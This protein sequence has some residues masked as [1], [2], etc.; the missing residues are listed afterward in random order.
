MKRRMGPCLSVTFQG[1]CKA[2]CCENKFAVVF[3]EPFV[4]LTLLCVGW[5]GEGNA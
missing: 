2:H 4:S 1:L 3:E 5:Q